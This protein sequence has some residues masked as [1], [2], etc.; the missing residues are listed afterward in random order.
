[1]RRILT[2]VEERQ[3][4]TGQER[5]GLMRSVRAGR[6]VERIGQARVGEHD[7]RDAIAKQWTEF[8]PA[9][10]GSC[11]RPN[12]YLPSYVEWLTCLEMRRDVREL[13]QPFQY[14]REARRP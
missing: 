1:M 10:K 6:I 7:A 14:T 13:R 4:E 5:A 9:D 11:V 8:L 2:L 12:V 3:A